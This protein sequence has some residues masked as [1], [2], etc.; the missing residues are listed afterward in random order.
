MHIYLCCLYNCTNKDITFKTTLNF[1][2]HLVL[3]YNCLMQFG[4]STLLNI[5]LSQINLGSIPKCSFMN[6]VNQKQWMTVKTIHRP[7]SE[8]I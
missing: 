1:F 3:L 5:Q 7:T 6:L 8:V 4:I 2:Q